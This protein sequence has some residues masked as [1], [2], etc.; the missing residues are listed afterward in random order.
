M[1]W[2]MSKC[3]VTFLTLMEEGWRGL[4]KVV[5]YWFCFH[6]WSPSCEGKRARPDWK[7]VMSRFCVYNHSKPVWGCIP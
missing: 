5:V 2:G 1:V 7:K 6:G 3:C 4:E